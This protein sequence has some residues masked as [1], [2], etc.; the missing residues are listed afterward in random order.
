MSYLTKE[1]IEDGLSELYEIEEFTSEDHNGVK[2]IEC[3]KLKDI[4]GYYDYLK[5]V[6]ELP[7]IP[8]STNFDLMK[9]IEYYEKSFTKAMSDKELEAKT[10]VV[11]T[12]D[13][14]E[15]DVYKGE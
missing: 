1:K 14:V 8:Y 5:L 6:D 7:S 12:S 4:F 9:V 15:K 10:S 3:S 11:D 13:W 2:R